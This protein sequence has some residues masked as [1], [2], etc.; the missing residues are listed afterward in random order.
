MFYWISAPRKKDPNAPQPEGE[1]PH[2]E[3]GI[4][5]LEDVTEQIHGSQTGAGG[6]QDQVRTHPLAMDKGKGKLGQSDVRHISKGM[7]SGE[8]SS[9]FTG[10]GQNTG[11][12]A[13]LTVVT[14]SG[15]GVSTMLGDMVGGNVSERGD[16]IICNL[17]SDFNTPT[18][19]MLPIVG[20]GSPLEGDDDDCQILG[21]G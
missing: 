3:S 5:S 17:I 18:D 20:R 4:I 19:E 7:S 10:M 9:H 21:T 11:T 12:L 1:V 16:S 13:L 14:T 2:S 15:G 8:G 6:Q